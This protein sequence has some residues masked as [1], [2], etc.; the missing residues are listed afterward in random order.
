[1]EK[2]GNF[3]MK[4]NMDIVILLTQKFASISIIDIDSYA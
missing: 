2:F 1:M 3:L 4:N